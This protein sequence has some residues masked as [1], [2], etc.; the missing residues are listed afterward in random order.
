MD[1]MKLDKKTFKQEIKK[2]INVEKCKNILI[3]IFQLFEIN[4]VRSVEAL[5]IINHMADIINEH[6]DEIEV[7][8]IIEGKNI[9][10]I[11]EGE[12]ENDGYN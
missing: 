4:K 9:M 7:K 11:T 12:A 5:N 8:L 1:E 2:N 10:K 3:T 6:H